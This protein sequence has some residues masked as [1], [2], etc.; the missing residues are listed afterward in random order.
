MTKQKVLVVGATSTVGRHVVDQLA[1]AKRLEPVAAVRSPEKAKAFL[2]KGVSTIELDL[3]SIASVQDAV[4]GIDSIFLLTG[5]TVDMVIQSKLV[6]D[7]AEAA[8]VNHIVHMGA[9]APDDTDLGHF[10]W[11]Q[12][13][14]RYIESSR[15]G[16][17]HVAPN[18]FMQNM[19]GGGSLW[20][21]FSEGNISGSRPI[22]AFTAD[23]RLG[24]VAAED[25]ARV[26]VA[27]LQEPNKHARKKYNLS[28]E[29]R[30]V[31][32]IAAILTETLGHPF[33]AV[34]HDPEAF[35][36]A[37]LDGGME[38]TY[39]A[40]ARETLLRFGKN[41]IPGQG[42]IFPF[43]EIVGQAPMDWPS[44]AR[45]HRTEFLR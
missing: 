38:P 8:G 45:A 43:E 18:M 11:H 33:H 30:S 44:F 17:T 39:A 2:E 16:W 1:Q 7:Q 34:T 9:W 28:V 37:L 22:H 19:L 13:V 32:E 4:R 6:V 23:A 5:Y 35:Y 27:A 20:G 12:M 10:G 25:I 29:V 36:R 40:C 15:L 26:S 41:A 14:E 21:S 31:Q 3:S 42:Q 24:W